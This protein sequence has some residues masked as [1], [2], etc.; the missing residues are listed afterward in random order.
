[1]GSVRGYESGALGPLDVSGANMGA[2]RRATG[3]AE[4]LWHAFDIGPTPIIVSM[5]SDYGKFSR[6]SNSAIDSVSAG[7][8][9][10]GISVPMSFGIARFS[11]ADPR[12]DTG[13]TQRFQF[14]ARANWK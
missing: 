6:G 14:D 8:K 9:G 3:S 4:L 2:E 11:F 12:R 7:S 10:L 13:R 5:F 1:V